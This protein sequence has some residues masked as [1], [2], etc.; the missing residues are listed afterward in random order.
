MPQVLFWVWVIFRLLLGS[1]K[2]MKK[3]EVINLTSSCLSIVLK[4]EC[5]E[6]MRYLPRGVF[7]LF[8]FWRYFGN[9]HRNEMGV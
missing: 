8:F 4:A 5:L 7:G 3:L 6:K 2:L 9:L 1:W